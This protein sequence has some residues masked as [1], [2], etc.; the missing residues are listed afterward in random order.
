MNKALELF[1]AV[2]RMHNC[3]QAVGCGL[4]RDELFAE[5]AECGGGRA[6]EGRCGALHAAMRIVGPARAEEV[7]SKFAAAL[8]SDKCAVLKRELRVPC[9]ECVAAAAA[10]AEEN[11]PSSR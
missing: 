6:P 11:Q 2:P 4:G 3:A 5:L 7:R 10:L 1:T 9:A 8:G